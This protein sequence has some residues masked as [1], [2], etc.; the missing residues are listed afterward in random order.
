[1]SRIGVKIYVHTHTHTHTNKHTHTRAQT[2]SKNTTKV[3]TPHTIQGT[4][5][6]LSMLCCTVKPVKHNAG[7]ENVLLPQ[8][9]IYTYMYMYLLLLSQEFSEQFLLLPEDSQFLFLFLILL[10][11]LF[12]IHTMS[13]IKHNRTPSTTKLSNPYTCMCVH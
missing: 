2:D 1:M 12:L 3:A 4:K 13:G 6:A 9:D 8:W 10:T 7:K 11:A 5:I